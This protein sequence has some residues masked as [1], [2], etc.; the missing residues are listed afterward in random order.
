MTAIRSTSWWFTMRRL[1]RGLS[2]PAALS[3]SL[4]IEQK[5]KGKAE[6]N[7]RLFA[8]PRRSHSEQGLQDI[9]DL[10]KPTQQ[11]LE[12]FFIA[13]DELE[14]KKLEIIGWKGPKAAI[15]AIKDAAKTFAK[16]SR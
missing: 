4:Q 13:T 3:A 11:E 6:R 10:S 5:R 16:N 8:V 1:F 9:R 12:K 14:D 7:D 15:Q 2:C